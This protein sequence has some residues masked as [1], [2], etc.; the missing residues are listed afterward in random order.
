MSWVTVRSSPGALFRFLVLVSCWAGKKKKIDLNELMKNSV[1]LSTT[2]I[3]RVSELSQLN[4]PLSCSFFFLLSFR[5]KS[6]RLIYTVFPKSLSMS[7]W[8]GLSLYPDSAFLWGFLANGPHFWVWLYSWIKFNGSSW[9]FT[10]RS[11]WNDIVS[12]FMHNK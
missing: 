9:P 1:S 10:T 6:I 4:K 8:F 11:M 5:K 2:G 7:P 12:R 3:T